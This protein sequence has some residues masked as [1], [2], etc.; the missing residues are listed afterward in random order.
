MAES[1]EED[2]VKTNSAGFLLVTSV[3]M[4]KNQM[5]V[6]SP[7]PKPLPRTLLILSDVTYMDIQ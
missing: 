1:V 2:V 4:E 3:D 5:T 6:L 7:A